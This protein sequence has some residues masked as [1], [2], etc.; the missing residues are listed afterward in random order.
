[1]TTT[2]V[3]AI[4]YLSFIGLG[5]P[6]A[7]LGSAWPVMQQAMHAPTWGAGLVQ[8]LTSLCTII[9]SLNSA[10]LIRRFGTGRLTALSTGLTALA[11]LGMAF[12]REFPSLLFVVLLSVPMGLGAG[13]VDAALNNYVALHFEPRHMSWLH[14]SWGLGTIIGPFFMARG[15]YGN[16]LWGYGYGVVA[17]IQAG[18]SIALFLTLPLWKKEETAEEAQR[19]RTLS[20][21]QVLALPGAK[22]GMA[23]FFGYCALES[24]LMLWAPTF[25]VRMRGVQQAQAPLYATMFCIGITVGRGVSGFMTLRFLPKQMVRIGQAVLL[26]GGLMLFAPDQRAAAVGLVICGLG[27]AP[28]YPNIIQDTPVNYGAENSQAAIGVQMA[29]AYFGSTCMPTVFGW[30]ASLVGFW[31]MPVVVLAIT[32]MMAAMFAWQK[33]IVESRNTILS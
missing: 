5:L 14:C 15:M 13:A 26:S 25:M 29:V 17:L 23:T 7:M 22:Q 20:V 16:A 8:M 24:L 1:M 6:D 3:L 18:L 28:I 11:L 21:A 31:L 12:S 2:L 32:G 9:S 33:Q 10:R 4:I 27:C 30:L 19:T